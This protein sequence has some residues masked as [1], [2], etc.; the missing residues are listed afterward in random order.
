MMVVVVVNLLYLSV[1]FRE[2]EP[3]THVKARSL[4]QRCCVSESHVWQPLCRI[5]KTYRLH[6]YTQGVL[7][8]FLEEVL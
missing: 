8:D 6:I 5:G 3:T 1:F 2:T 7:E 4:Q